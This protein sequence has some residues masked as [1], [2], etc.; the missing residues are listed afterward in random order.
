MVAKAGRQRS[1]GRLWTSTPCLPPRRDPAYSRNPPNECRMTP[2]MLPLLKGEP[3]QARCS[4]TAF[5]GPATPPMDRLIQWQA[6]THGAAARQAA[7]RDTACLRTASS[8]SPQ[9]SISGPLPRSR[10]YPNPSAH[11]SSVAQVTRA[12]CCKSPEA[13]RTVARH[14]K[15]ATASCRMWAFTCLV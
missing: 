9:T 10:L 5:K 3:G 1:R 13:I 15:E 12:G 11:P 2:V 4:G 6:T 8:A 7:I 14:Q